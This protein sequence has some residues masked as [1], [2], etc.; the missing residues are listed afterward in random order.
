[1]GLVP[2]FT[3]ETTDNRDI[4][5]TFAEIVTALWVAQP[6]AKCWHVAPTG[7]CKAWPSDMEEECRQRGT[8]DPN[9]EE[10][11]PCSANTTDAPTEA[12]TEAPTTE[13]PTD[14]PTTEAPTDAPTTEEP[15]DAPTTEEP[16]DAPTNPPQSRIR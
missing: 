7:S 15:T 8:F 4:I 9:Y 14:A 1:M 6:P 16:T 3:C 5:G 2:W 10:H 12:P 11:H 13:E